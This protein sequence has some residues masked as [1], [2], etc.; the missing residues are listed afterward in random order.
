MMLL[1]VCSFCPWVY[2]LK[3]LENAALMIASTLVYN[4]VKLSFMVIK[5]IAVR[6]N[7]AKSCCCV[8]NL[9]CLTVR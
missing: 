6:I 7:Q 9:S 8:L 5:R 1:K 4:S 2:M 3:T